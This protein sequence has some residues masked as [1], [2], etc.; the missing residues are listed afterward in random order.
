MS[1]I[2]DRGELDA[3]LKSLAQRLDA[4]RLAVTIYVVGGG[5]SC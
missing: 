2:F 3:A 1:F 4:D 5:R